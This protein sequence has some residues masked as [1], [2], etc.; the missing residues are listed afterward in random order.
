VRK[1][2]VIAAMCLIF[3]SCR[4]APPTNQVAKNCAGRP[5]VNFTM[6]SE[7]DSP[8]CTSPNLVYHAN[9]ANP[10]F[11]LPITLF[12][13][14]Y[15]LAPDG[16]VLPETA[17]SQNTINDRGGLDTQICSADVVVGQPTV[18]Q[19]LHLKCITNRPMPNGSTSANCTAQEQTDFILKPSDAG[20]KLSS[21]SYTLY[22]TDAHKK[23]VLYAPSALSTTGNIVG[24]VEECNQ[25]CP[26]AQHCIR[27]SST[28]FNGGLRNLIG[29]WSTGR[30]VTKSQV[31][32]AL[33]IP[34]TCNRSDQIVNSKGLV[35]NVSDKRCLVPL[36]FE[37][38][39]IKLTI[40]D[41]VDG[42]AGMSASGKH[43]E[44]EPYRGMSIEFPG[45]DSV[46]GG[47]I[48]GIA[49][50]NKTTV[51]DMRTPTSCIR[52]DEH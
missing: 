38:T 44:F 19:D 17:Q 8:Q 5:C 1:L 28:S 43:V 33:G 42:R 23:N 13:S 45:D 9:A 6:A 49:A 50:P 20:A 31:V 36:T 48:L 29:G 10:D 12:Y 11:T 46:Y 2:I 51:V 18:T 26:K 32:K 40:A 41:K 27:V 7:A 52:V 47:E 39:D 4:Q 30:I 37:G 14:T 21:T 15:R 22:T 24:D 16:T 25:L 3:L 35:E 34:D